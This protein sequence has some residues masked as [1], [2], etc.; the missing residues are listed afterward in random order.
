MNKILKYGLLGVGGI[1]A[2][3]A[4]GVA[5]VA[6]T[7]N[8]ND[9]KAQII[10][11]VKDSKQRNLRLDGDIKLSFFPSIGANLSKVSLS[12]FNSD[13]EFVAIEFARVS[14]AL[15][16]LLSK[17]VVVDEVAVSGLKATL[18]KHKDGTTNI[19]DL[20]GKDENKKDEKK[21]NGSQQV[22]FDIASVDIE[23]TD[24]SY[25]DEGTGAQYVIKDLNLKTGRIA[26]GSPGK[27]ALSAGVQANQ[28]KL[29][30][31]TQLKTTLRFDLDKQHYQ[32]EGLDLQVSGAV[33]NISNLEIK[34][35]GDASA[36]LA[37]QEFSAQKFMLHATGA[38]AKDNFEA[39]LNASALSFTKDKLSG[40]KLTLNAKLD[41][42]SGNIAAVLSVPS[43]EGSMKSFKASALA[44]DLNM[45]LPQPKLD[46]TAQIKT[47]LNLDLEK[48][49]FQLKGL[50]LQ[51]SGSA[52]DMSDLKIK[53][54][55]D[56]SANL[57]TQEFG[58]QKFSLHA[59]GMKVKDS[60]EATL[61]SP[62]LSL[63]KNKF[64]G[65]KLTLNA[66]LDGAFGNVAASLSLPGVEG[67]AQS[68][69]VSALALDL[70]VKQPEQAFKVKLSSPVSGSI[71]AQQINLSNLVIAVK[72]TG[73]K[74]P[75][76]SVSSEMKGSVQVDALKQNVQANLAGGLLQSKVKAKVGVKGFDHPAINFDVEVDQFDADLYLPKKSA[77]APKSKEPEQ[78]L[79]L[80]ALRTLNLDGS[81]RIG[82]L[83][84]ANVKSSQVRLEVKAHNGLVNLN[85]LS[86]N[87]YQGSMNGSLSLNAQATPSIAINQNLSGINIAPLLKDALN[88]DMLEGKGN[89]AVNLT[90]QGSTVSA[91]KKALNGKLSLN[92]ADGALKGIDIDKKLSAA[93]AMLSKG[94][95]TTQT[96]SAS[97][98]EKTDFKECK[99]TFKVNNG[100]AHN[101]DLSLKSQLIRISGA[102]D[103]NIGNDSIDYVA[104]ATLVKTQGDQGSITV[105]LRV[106]GPFTDLK[107][108]LDYAAMVKEA[109]KQKVDA[110]IESKKE[111]LKNQMQ[112]QLK[113]KLKG[114]FK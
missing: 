41:G 73:D 30:I 63:A 26:N 35:S 31:S 19:D 84:V 27:I 22:K 99:A 102:G 67:N 74:L 65:D 86:A 38:K 95:A 72:A 11:A 49:N 40:D 79:D 3:A 48:Q 37:T 100:I 10:K 14:L 12:E 111:E 24:L 89:V 42:A 88:L 7:F 32:L 112:E 78:P 92:L 56:A 34:A 110:K 16:P 58:A 103:I 44:L 21:K 97:K 54:S 68:F 15:M 4:A 105:P 107:Y 91:M 8:P 114:L 90:M 71:Q 25:R 94:S 106:S 83:K 70:D 13:K 33:L 23:K 61:D 93:Q 28:P 60:F 1:V 18:V 47:A 104:K 87:L 80:S 17:Q 36:N 62:Q 82:A 57:S 96:Q 101:D 113:G 50:D 108:T 20:L 66:K 81:L 64:S 5:Y 46:I 45:K 98:D 53:A 39:T 6:A 9:Y 51:A 55:G 43:L 75:N 76:K 52:L 109:V 85:P 2:V 29:D 69:K 59:T 77:D